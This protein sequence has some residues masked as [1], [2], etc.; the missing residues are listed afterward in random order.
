MIRFIQRNKLAT[1]LILIV[2]AER[3]SQDDRLIPR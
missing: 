2:S 3:Y 1:F